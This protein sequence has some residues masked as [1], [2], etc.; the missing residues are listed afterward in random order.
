MPTLIKKE[1]GIHDVEHALAGE[2]GPGYRVKVTSETSLRVYRN[3][4]IWASVHVT[5]P[6]GATDIR[7]RPGGFILVML[8]NALYT[9]PK[10]RAALRRGL[11]A[12]G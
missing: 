10:V 8:L 11:E 2:L 3:P 9:V 4:A 1:I 12:A 6:G 5:W 7:V